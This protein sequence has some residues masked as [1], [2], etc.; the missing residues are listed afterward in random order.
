MSVGMARPEPR[1][2]PTLKNLSEGSSLNLSTHSFNLN[3]LSFAPLLLSLGPIAVRELLRAHALPPALA[4]AQSGLLLGSTQPDTSPIRWRAKAYVPRNKAS[5]MMADVL[6]DNGAHGEF[7]SST[8]AKR[9]GLK[10]IALEV[11]TTARLPS[12]ATM[13][14]THV[15]EPVTIDM[16]RQ[17]KADL[18]F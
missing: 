6:V 10:L 14:I 16:D 2:A 15:T 12:G 1:P 3:P 8:L 9:L 17:Y 18:Q 11:P 13:P 4:R 5:P 7:M